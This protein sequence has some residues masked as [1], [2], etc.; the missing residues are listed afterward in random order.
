MPMT[1]QARLHRAVNV[2]IQFGQS[3]E[4][5]LDTFERRTFKTVEDELIDLVQMFENADPRAEVREARRVG[6]GA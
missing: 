3:V 6:V 5:K 4:L 2:L 1:P